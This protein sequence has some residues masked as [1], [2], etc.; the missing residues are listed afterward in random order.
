M[1]TANDHL[2][3]APVTFYWDS[4]A[5][6]HIIAMDQIMPGGM[7]TTEP[8]ISLH[9]NGMVGHW[10]AL[11]WKRG[12]PEGA[13]HAD[14][15]LVESISRFGKTQ[16]TAQTRALEKVMKLGFMKPK[17]LVFKMRPKALSV[18]EEGFS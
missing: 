18:F 15:V 5:Q 11:F 2:Q 13:A 1:T 9:D 16:A 17:V 3:E 6:R 12:Y 7:V 14:K 10:T 8:T 4:D